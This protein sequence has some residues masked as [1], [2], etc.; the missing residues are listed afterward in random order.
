VDSAPNRAHWEKLARGGDAQ[1]KRALAI[2]DW[3]LELA[4]L[5]D[6]ASELH[7][8]SGVGMGGLM[9]LSY[10]TIADYSRLK[11]VYFKPHEIEALIAIDAAMLYPDE[12]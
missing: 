8:R 10:T 12:G 2:P 7:G 3:P 5:W 4:Y 9:P 11:D 1:A 6:T